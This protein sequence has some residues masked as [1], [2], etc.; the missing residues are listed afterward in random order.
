MITKFNI[1]EQNITDIKILKNKPVFRNKMAN[2]NNI[3][4]TI[5][6]YELPVKKIESESY[7][8]KHT[9][10]FHRENGPAFQKWYKNGQKFKEI[11]YIKGKK[12]RENNAASLEW[13]E[14]GQIKYIIYYIDDKCHN[15]NGPAFQKFDIN[16]NIVDIS[17]Y[18]EDKK[19]EIED[20]L[21]ELRYRNSIYYEEQLLKYDL[22]KYN[23]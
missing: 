20:W 14:N 19:Y 18:L 4:K 11:Y 10:Y 2:I 13:Y 5:K 8:I 15:E 17:Y 9:N 16:G 22:K 12:H 1:F 3:K 7:K 23:L 21:K 6:Y